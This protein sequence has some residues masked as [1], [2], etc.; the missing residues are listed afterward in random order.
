MRHTHLVVRQARALPTRVAILHGP[1]SGHL[2]RTG[3][4]GALA[5]A[6]GKGDASLRVLTSEVG[7][8]R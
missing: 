4:A 1:T 3:L 6:F 5:G 2:R 8:F 7:A